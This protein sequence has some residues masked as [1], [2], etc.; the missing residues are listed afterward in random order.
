MV[1]E[2]RV[3]QYTVQPIQYIMDFLVP[4][5]VGDHLATKITW[6]LMTLVNQV[7][8]NKIYRPPKQNLLHSKDSPCFA[9]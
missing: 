6:P 7:F 1:H 4:S 9:L 3:L 2:N 8:S 5:G